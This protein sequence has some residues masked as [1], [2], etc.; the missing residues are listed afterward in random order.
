MTRRSEIL[1]WFVGAGALYGATAA[2]TLQ[3]ADGSKLT[4][5]ALNGYLPS[6]NPGD[7]PGW[8]LLA[9]LWLHLV[10]LAPALALPLLSAVSG[11]AGVVLLHRLVER[12][13]GLAAARGAA[14]VLLVAH[15]LW[16]SAATTETYAPA[17]TLALGSA[18]LA[19]REGGFGE[20]FSAGLAAGVG[21]ACHLFSLVISG[22]HLV[23]GGVRRLAGAALG[24][25]LGLAPVW[26]GLLTIPADPL[27]GHFAGG[28]ASIGWC[29]QSFLHLEGMAAGGLRLAALVLFGLGPLGLAGVIWARSGERP[30]RLLVAVVVAYAVLLSGYAVYRQHLM[31]LFLLVG[32]LLVRPPRLDRRFMLAHVVVQLVLYI[33]VPAVLVSAGH[34]DLGVRRLPERSNAWYFL[35][36]VKTLDRGAE[37]YAREL[38][39]AAP[40]DAVIL[41]DFNL[42]AVVRATQS[43]HRLRPDVLVVPTF[44]DDALGR[45]QPAARIAAGIRRRLAAGRPVVLADRWEPYYRTTELRDRFHLD[46][47]ACGPGLLVREAPPALA[48][49]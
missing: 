44:I 40:R 24:F 16:W 17:L 11:A 48:S 35:C 21:A 7:H 15:P 6:L 26:L 9:M 20:A 28:A 25:V 14:L 23:R 5:Y 39:S 37:S 45:A 32:L 49:P 36:P 30:P 2:R 22:P 12:S 46:L 13:A 41:A 33:M 27:T 31:V 10:P 18:L 29:L 19:R 3:W 38:L 8:S 1:G 47:T 42:G 43:L 4:L 34:G